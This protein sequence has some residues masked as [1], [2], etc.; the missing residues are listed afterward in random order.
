MPEEL[1]APRS[2]DQDADCNTPVVCVMPYMASHI[3]E[4]L[5]IK[6]CTAANCRMKR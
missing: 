1:T 4:Q 5:G 3:Y 2:G 6:Q